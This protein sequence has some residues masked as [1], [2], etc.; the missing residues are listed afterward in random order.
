M[1]YL[2]K[3]SKIFFFLFGIE[4]AL[5]LFINAFNPGLPITSNLRLLAIATAAASL[6][7]TLLFRERV[8]KR[9]LWFRRAVVITISGA[10]SV[11]CPIMVGIVRRPNFEGY[12]AYV[13]S[14]AAAFVALSVAAYVI[15][16]I[17][18]KITLKKINRKLEQNK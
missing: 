14:V 15:A 9:S 10:V 2:K 7:G 1:T 18:E 13:L 8:T 5:H 4:T 17:I 11:S 6:S 3:S 12:L 16:D